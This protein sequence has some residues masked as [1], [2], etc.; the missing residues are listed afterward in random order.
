MT[1]CFFGVPQIATVC[2]RQARSST[3]DVSNK[4]YNQSPHFVFKK[5][6]LQCLMLY[7]CSHL[8]AEQ[9]AL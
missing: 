7:P 8:I 2:R 4:F 6:L 3:P 5:G 1:V 9:M